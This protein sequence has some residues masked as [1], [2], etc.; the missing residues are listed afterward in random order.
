MLDTFASVGADR[1]DL[2]ITD[3]HGDKVQFS[4]GLRLGALSRIL[5]DQL[6]TTAQ[7]LQNI[8]IRPQGTGI[9]F[10][11]LDDLTAAAVDR[12]QVFTFMTLETSLGNHQAWLV[13]QPSASDDFVRRLRKGVGADPSASGATRVAGS[14]N[15]KAKYAPDFPRVLI[16]SS[17]PGLI[18]T[19]EQ[20]ESLGLVA[21]P[22]V[23]PSRPV[24]IPRP[25]QG[26]KRWPRYDLCL[27]GAPP[28]RDQAGPDKSRADFTWCMTAIDWGW[29]TDATASQLLEISDK[30]RE[31]GERY[32]LRTAERAAE[33]VARNRQPAR[34]E[35]D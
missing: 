27:A 16:T 35:P 15:F 21:P 10:V 14:L 9:Q 33:A 26:E 4:R 3:L 34:P 6:A 13:L 11:Q 19:P 17:V 28:N 25:M 24:R 29:G 22:P 20:L 7:Q 30:A 32:A 8:I 23:F 1:F 31:N 12:V 2:T 18:V 5:P